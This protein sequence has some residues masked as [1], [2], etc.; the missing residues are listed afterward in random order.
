MELP[1][2]ID[3]EYAVYTADHKLVAMTSSTDDAKLIV[4][5]VNNHDRLVGLAK[6][7]MEDLEC[8]GY[9]TTAGC[10]KAILAELEG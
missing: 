4:K 1:L 6:S 5:A 3:G 2:T 9:P 7:Y 10:V 8:Q